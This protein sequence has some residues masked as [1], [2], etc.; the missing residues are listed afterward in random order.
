MQATPSGFLA[1]SVPVDYEKAL[2]SVRD[3]QKRSGQDP[4]DPGAAYTVP[5]IS[6]SE[7]K[8]FSREKPF[9]CHT[10]RPCEVNATRPTACE[11]SLPPAERLIADALRS[12]PALA[13]NPADPSA[14]RAP[15]N[16]GVDQKYGACTVRDGNTWFGISYY[17]GEGSTGIGG[18]GRYDP[19]TRKLELRRPKVL[20]ES[21]IFHLLHDGDYLWLGTAGEYECEGTPPTLGLVR[22]DWKTGNALAFLDGSDGPCGLLVN[23]LAQVGDDV[24]VATDLGLSRWNRK[25][26]KWRNYVLDAAASPPARETSCPDLYR[27]LLQTLPRSGWNEVMPAESPYHQLTKT[28]AR[29]RPRALDA[30]TLADTQFHILSSGGSAGEWAYRARDFNSAQREFRAR[31]EGGNAFFQYN[32]GVLYARGEGVNRDFDQAASWWRKAA[33]HYAQARR[34]LGLL[35]LNR[36]R[37]KA[38]WDEAKKWLSEAAAHGSDEVKGLL[39]LMDYS[40]LPGSLGN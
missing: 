36:A 37:T 15:G 26:S 39:L 13:E 9:T 35:L 11:S 27:R 32:L 3:S 7:R 19:K 12:E 1:F 29:L 10:A 21:S 18:I 2:A 34:D 25:T 38:E 22:Y 40:T 4:N 28:L 30:V 17:R 24:W 23:G 6:Y 33:P 8:G 20:R 31:A 5:V 16:N 14:P